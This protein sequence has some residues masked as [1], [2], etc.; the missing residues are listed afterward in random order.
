MCPAILCAYRPLVDGNKVTV[1]VQVEEA[2]DFCPNTS[3]NLDIINAAA[4]ARR[5]KRWPQDA[6]GGQV[7]HESGQEQK[8]T[9]CGYYCGTAATL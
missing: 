2:G 8:N 1:I 5:G 3:G 9:Y 7:S 4:V 6:E